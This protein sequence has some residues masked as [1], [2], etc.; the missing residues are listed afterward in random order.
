MDLVDYD[1][2]AFD[3][4][5]AEYRASP[6]RSG[7]PIG[8]RSRYR[9]WPATMSS[10]GATRC[11]GMPGRACS[12]IS[13][14]FRSTRGRCRASRSGCRCSGSTGPTRISAAS[15][16]R[17]RRA[18]VAAGAEVRVLPSGRVTR[19]ERIVTAGGDLDQAVAGQSVTLTLRRRGG[20]LARRRDCG[21]GRSARSGR[22]VRSDD[23]VDGRAGA[24]ARTR[25]LAQDSAPRRSPRRSR[26]RNMR[27]TS[28]RSTIS[29]RRR[30]N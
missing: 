23:R 29:R 21:R 18:A 30:W 12:N 19:I 3:A 11:R 17:S 4:I 28:T 22:P 9:G 20:L 27:S 26:S 16:A 10:A 14:R 1:Q 7:S 6:R 13:T 24:A 8:W 5:A 25:L 2:G 15:P